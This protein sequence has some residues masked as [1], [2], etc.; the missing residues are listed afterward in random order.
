MTK[1]SRSIH[2]FLFMSH[3]AFPIESFGSG[4]NRLLNDPDTVN[5]S[6]F[7]DKIKLSTGPSTP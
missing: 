4:V 1:D 5:I 2:D 6:L 7:V 3:K